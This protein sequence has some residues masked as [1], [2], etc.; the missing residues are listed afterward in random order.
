M[1]FSEFEE[2][3]NSGAK[4]ITLTE[5]VIISDE[6]T[7]K[8]FE[9]NFD[10]D[11]LIIDGNN[12]EFVSDN[13]ITLNFKGYAIVLKNLSFKKK[14]RHYVFNFNNYAK[15][16]NVSFDNNCSIYNIN[17]RVQFSNCNLSN[18]ITKG[19]VDL[20]K[21]NLNGFHNYG[22]V[23][24]NYCTVRFH[25]S[26]IN[27][28]KL[29]IYNSIFLSNG[30]SHC[31][32]NKGYLKI[33]GSVF[34]NVEIYDS[35]AII[36]NEKGVIKLQDTTFEESYCAFSYVYTHYN[37]TGNIISN[38]LGHVEAY[39]CKFINESS[40]KS[41][42]GIYNMGASLILD[43]CEFKGIS[44]KFIY[45]DDY[46]DNVKKVNE[47]GKYD[48]G[49]M[50]FSSSVL[51]KNCK[52]EDHNN[53]I[54]GN[55]NFFTL[56]ESMPVVKK[57]N[58]ENFSDLIHS[59]QKEIKLNHYRINLTVDEDDI[60]IDG[61]GNTIDG[62]IYIKACNVTLK[63]IKLEATIINRGKS[64]KIVDC[65]FE[66]SSYHSS[67]GAVRNEGTVY[68]E[69]SLFKECVA[70]IDGGAIYN[71]EGK[72][73]LKNCDFIRNRSGR[74]GGAIYNEKG[75]LSILN[76]NFLDNKV[77]YLGET[78]YR[79]ADAIFNSNG[80][81]NIEN[82]NFN[83]NDY[84]NENFYNS[85]I[86]NIF[87]SNIEGTVLNAGCLSIKK[88]QFEKGSS[89]E[90]SALIYIFESE[91]EYL[92]NFIEKHGKERGIFGF[93]SPTPSYM[94]GG[95]GKIRYLDELCDGENKNDFNH[96]N[97]LINSNS[98]NNDSLE[99]HLDGNIINKDESFENGI[100][101]SE[102]KLIIDGNDHTIDANRKSG[103]FNISSADVTLR[104]I[105]FK[106]SLSDTV[107]AINISNSN[108]TLEN[109]IFESNDSIKRGGSLNIKYSLLKAI[110]CEFK[111]NFASGGGA[112]YAN[113]SSVELLGCEFSKNS[114]VNAGAAISL[115]DSDLVCLKSNFNMNI[116]KDGAVCEA[117]TSNL[118]FHDCGFKNN[119]AV[120]TGGAIATHDSSVKFEECIFE[121]NKSDGSAIIFGM[122]N[123]KLLIKKSK[124]ICNQTNSTLIS[125]VGEYSALFGQ[126]YCDGCNFENNDV[127][128]NLI[129]VRQLYL[130]GCD[131][132]NNQYGDDLIEVREFLSGD[133]EGV[134]KSKIKAEQFIENVNTEIDFKHLFDSGQKDISLKSNYIFFEDVKLDADGL[135]IDGQEHE[136]TGNLTITGK[137]AT[138]KNIIFKDT[139]IIENNDTATLENCIFKSY[140]NEVIINKAYLTLKNC[141]FESNK[142]EVII[143]KA[144]LTLENCSF[145][146]SFKEKHRIL[147]TG[148]VTI[149]DDDGTKVTMDEIIKF[150]DEVDEKEAMKGLEALFG[151]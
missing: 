60:T 55:D 139:V 14:Y 56:D 69:N 130:S 62:E 79:I 109:C 82:S 4:K 7:G 104:N 30:G 64:L 27:E 88:C 21:C 119:L 26:F 128:F 111:D 90:N 94:M 20:Y 67:G 74:Y 146:C 36:Q 41:I 134:P 140:K 72:V 142:K 42:N 54:T 25:D 86:L 149:I 107:A 122:Y 147:N 47:D 126:L 70:E 76:C 131:F 75:S 136:I 3:I 80:R 32:E 100:E 120:N 141:S 15:L 138:L 148:E 61:C 53:I 143:N 44:E 112:I 83:R 9:I 24:L 95:M 106:N 31:L 133:N 118:S 150:Y 137:N 101:I 51:L 123:V 103:I 10:E 125:V 105:V 117:G 35:R 22:E 50:N 28:K 43:S 129:K 68:I 97:D 13:K 19:E 46:S 124:F 5:D 37:Q 18:L 65:I 110:D 116:A 12:H 71:A 85:G 144:N 73:I 145:K 77:I 49:Y 17:R 102:I 78:W 2:L 59:G 113:H 114:A 108:I 96:L 121:K 63:N 89:I 93:N 40:E 135:C 45:N 84:C 87:N 99:I 57:I 127:G 66:D 8:S 11:N 151:Q 38:M 115:D 6:D 29:G 1:N 33:S 34:K 23:D 98:Q 48:F 52:Y 81:V 58:G 92:N 16:D 132:R 91:E 39:N